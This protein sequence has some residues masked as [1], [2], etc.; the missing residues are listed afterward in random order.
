[1]R[2]SR[3]AG[4]APALLDGREVARSHEMQSSGIARG[5]EMQS[6]GAARGHE[7]QS[8]ALARG[9]EMQS[10]STP[11]AFWSERARAETPTSADETCGITTA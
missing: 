9:H 4:S 7:M 6:S 11:H 8:S 2:R 5:H 3:S 1:M 10:A